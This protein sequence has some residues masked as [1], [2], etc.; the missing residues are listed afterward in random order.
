MIILI[1]RAAEK[2]NPAFKI[3]ST[4]LHNVREYAEG[5]DV[6]LKADEETGRLCIVAMNEGGHNCT[7]VDLLDLLAWLKT[8][9][10]ELL[11]NIPAQT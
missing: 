8:N 7:A 9:R 6:T 10:P 1:L 2:P 3:E 4:T 11:P 5:F